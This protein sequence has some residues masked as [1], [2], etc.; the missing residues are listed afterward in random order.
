[1]EVSKQIVWVASRRVFQ[2][3]E[4]V[5]KIVCAQSEMLD[6]KCDKVNMYCGCA[7]FF[8]SWYQERFYILFANL[9]KIVV[10]QS[11]S[12]VT[13]PEVKCSKCDQNIE[14]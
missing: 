13:N 1:M 7:M 12:I 8:K 4:L 9:I 3:L 10:P 11:W 6:A 5:N 14:I 2:F